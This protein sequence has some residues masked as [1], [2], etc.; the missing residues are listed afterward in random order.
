[1]PIYIDGN[2]TE[3]TLAITFADSAGLLILK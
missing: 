1:M 3:H 2:E